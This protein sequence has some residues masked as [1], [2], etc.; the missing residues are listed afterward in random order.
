MKKINKLIKIANNLDDSGFLRLADDLD[1]AISMYLEKV[2]QSDLKARWASP[3]NQTKIR[4]YLEKIGLASDSFDVK[5]FKQD[6]GYYVGYQFEEEFVNQELQDFVLIYVKADADLSTIDTYY[7]FS[8]LEGVAEEITFQQFSLA[9]NETESVVDVNAADPSRRNYEREVINIRQDPC[10][11]L[12]FKFK[13]EKEDF[14]SAK[15]ED[16]FNY[17]QDNVSEKAKMM[18]GTEPGDIGKVWRWTGLWGEVNLQDVVKEANE[19]IMQDLDLVTLTT[20]VADLTSVA[21]HF[22]SITATMSGAAAALFGVGGVLKGL[23]NFLVAAGLDTAEITLGMALAIERIVK[24]I[25]RFPPGGCYVYIKDNKEACV[26]EINPCFSSFPTQVSGKGR[27][28]A[29]K[30]IPVR[31]LNYLTF[32]VRGGEDPRFTIDNEEIIS[33]G[34]TLPF[35]ADEDGFFEQILNQVRQAKKDMSERSAAGR[36]DLDGD[37]FTVRDG[38]CNDSDSSIHPGAPDIS[39]DGID[40]D[41]DGVDAT[42]PGGGSGGGITRIVYQDVETGTDYDLFGYFKKGEPTIKSKKKIYIKCSD[43]TAYDITLQIYMAAQL[44]A[45]EKVKEANHRTKSSVSLSGTDHIPN[46]AN[47]VAWNAL[48]DKNNRVNILT[49]G[50]SQATLPSGS[51][52]DG[53]RLTTCPADEAEALQMVKDL[54]LE[55]QEELPLGY[56]N[57]KTTHS[58]DV[59]TVVNDIIGAS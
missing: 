17:E 51:L 32:Q 6:N 18:F 35:V 47:R 28:L 36:V 38:D 8:P 50:P 27:V 12:I 26:L 41:C 3:Y 56:Y 15:Q 52:K 16:T 57:D 45:L 19:I 30:Q 49:V 37:G 1:S 31:Y 43:G 34:K 58:E 22:S 44:V 13:T 21:N 4:S 39:G 25:Q 10:A 20:G 9:M 46:K 14:L 54:S 2:A 33:C 59:E 23:A 24:K 29:T 11:D 48:T 5:Y 7:S 53:K 55:T 40:Q 42:A